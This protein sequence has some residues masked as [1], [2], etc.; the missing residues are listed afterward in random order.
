MRTYKSQ[1]FDG[2]SAGINLW[3]KPLRLLQVYIYIFYLSIYLSRTHTHT[4][5]GSI[6]SVQAFK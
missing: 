6:W 4:Q 5:N 2:F 3:I 1:Q